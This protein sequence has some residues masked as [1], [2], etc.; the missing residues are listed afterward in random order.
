[1]ERHLLLVD[2]EANVLAALR[3]ALRR[4]GYQIHTAGGGQ[5]G[6]AILAEQ[7]ISVIISDQRMPHMTGS[8]FLEQARQ[9]KP[10]TVRI[11]LSGF[12]EV[13]SLADAINRGAAWKF[14][15]KPW[16]DEQLR[17]QIAEAFKLF[18]LEETNRK[19]TAAL[20]RS[21]EEMMR[22]NELMTDRF[23][24]AMVQ[25]TEELTHYRARWEALPLPVIE[26]DAAQHLVAANPAATRW[27]QR[28][29]DPAWP[30]D[31]IGEASPWG[32]YWRMPFQCEDQQHSLLLFTGATSA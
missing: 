3:R 22:L 2:D 19:L 7:P 30:Q 27:L 28:S 11:M 5:E 13:Q 20:Q 6:L 14:L 25:V 9:L 10:A 17:I 21:G 8:E 4:D 18:E 24:S 1:M 12:S 26:L 23:D 32:H 31:D 29:G 15:F 16:D